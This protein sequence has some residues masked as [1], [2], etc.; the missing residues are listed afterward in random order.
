MRI[1]KTRT[2]RETLGMNSA[3]ARRSTTHAAHQSGKCRRCGGFLV[4]DHCMDLQRNSENGFSSWAMR[5]LQCGDII[6]EAILRNR[7]FPH[8]LLQEDQLRAKSGGDASFYDAAPTV[9]KNAALRSLTSGWEKDRRDGSSIVDSLDE[10]E[11][12]PELWT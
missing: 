7:Y 9:M 6:D 4:D 12:S 2:P 1:T 10:S 11:N 5:C 8:Y 3:S